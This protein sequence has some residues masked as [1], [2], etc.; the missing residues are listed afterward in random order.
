MTD[1]A[2]DRV[3]PYATPPPQEPPKQ[4]DLT[5][6]SAIVFVLFVAPAAVALLACFGLFFAWLG[7]TAFWGVMA[8]LATAGLLIAGGL[9]FGVRLRR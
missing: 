4:S 3:L 5:K 1:D 2:D 8:F 6:V 9:A 7:M